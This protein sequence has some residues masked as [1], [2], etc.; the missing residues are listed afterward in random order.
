MATLNFYLDTADKNGRSFI[1]MTY[2]ANGQEF[3]HSVKI[4][5]TPNEW[6][7][8]KQRLKGKQQDDEF[9]NAHLNSLEEVIRKAER[10]CL[11][12]TT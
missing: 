4:K 2:L 6:L 1:Q 11:L 8:S 7:A 12:I 10:E 3:R 9:V 5:I